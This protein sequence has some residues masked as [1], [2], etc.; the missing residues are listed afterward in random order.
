MGQFGG[1]HPSA[2]GR[3]FIATTGAEV[4]DSFQCANGESR[5]LGSLECLIIARLAARPFAGK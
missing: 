5:P 2:F 4:G 1:G 3:K